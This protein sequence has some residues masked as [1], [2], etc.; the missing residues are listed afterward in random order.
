VTPD[1]RAQI[2]LLLARLADG[3]RAAIEPA[4]D[5]LWPLVRDFC[6]RAVG[7]ADAEDAAQQAIVRAFE[8][9]ADY[10]RERDAVAWVLTIAAWEVRTIR[11]RCARRRETTDDADIASDGASPEDAAIERELCTALRDALASLRPEDAATIT[12]AYFEASDAPRPATFRKRLQRALDRLR[13]AWRTK[14]GTP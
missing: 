2:T 9:V 12:A 13:G 1:A 3:D 4:F 8:R 11:R 7:A 14:H 5:A 6:A 10:D